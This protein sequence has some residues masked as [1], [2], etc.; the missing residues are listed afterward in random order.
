MVW[1]CPVHGVNQTKSMGTKL[2]L[3]KKLDT[4]SV[5]IP[6]F[7]FFCNDHLIVWA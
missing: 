2:N 4:K 5:I 7:Y 1:H 3:T 6:L